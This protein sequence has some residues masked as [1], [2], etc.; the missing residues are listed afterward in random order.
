MST[1]GFGAD[2]LVAGGRRDVG[3]GEDVILQTMTKASWAFALI[4]W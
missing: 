2:K 1:K 4:D 3:L